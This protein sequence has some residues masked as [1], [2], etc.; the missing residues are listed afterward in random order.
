MN[1]TKQSLLNSSKLGIKDSRDFYKGKSFNFSGDWTV[2]TH[3]HND[4]YIVD[5]VV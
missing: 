3:Y 1:N 5:F 4:D 2:G